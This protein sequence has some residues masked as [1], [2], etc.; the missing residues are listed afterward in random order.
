MKFKRKGKFVKEEVIT[1]YRAPVA[2]PAMR[3]GRLIVNRY[4]IQNRATGNWQPV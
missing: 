4:D 1:S 3:D 2:R